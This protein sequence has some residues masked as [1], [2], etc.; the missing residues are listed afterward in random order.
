[1][2]NSYS[3]PAGSDG[4]VMWWNVVALPDRV[5]VAA[6]STWRL[7]P[8]TTSHSELG[9]DPLFGGVVASVTSSRPKVLL[10]TQNEAKVSGHGSSGLGPAMA[11]EVMEG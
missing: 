2:G 6:P 7:S 8:S 11:D 4:T 3:A 9:N 5:G 10:S 1:M